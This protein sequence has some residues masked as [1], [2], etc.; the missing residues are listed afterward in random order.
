MEV[1]Q[2]R[3]WGSSAKEKKN[4]SVNGTNVA[5]GT[6]ERNALFFNKLCVKIMYSKKNHRTLR[7]GNW[8]CFRPQVRRETPTLLGDLER[9]NLNHWTTYVI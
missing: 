2:G 6:G 7:F 4:I 1:G 5:T 9:A 3:N 8:I